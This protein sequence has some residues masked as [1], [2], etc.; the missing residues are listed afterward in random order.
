MSLPENDIDLS[1]SRVGDFL[2]VKTNTSKDINVD[3]VSFIPGEQSVDVKNGENG[4]RTLRLTNVV[5]DVQSLGWTGQ[6][7][8]VNLPQS[9]EL[10]YAVLIHD[11]VNAKILDAA[12]ID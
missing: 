4:G 1:V 2:K 6:S 11:G 12:V 9:D 5:T 10:Q 3:V 7:V 8:S